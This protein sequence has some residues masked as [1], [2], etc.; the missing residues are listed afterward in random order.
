MGSVLI[1]E[2]YGQQGKMANQKRKEEKS[3]VRKDL[4]ISRK[5]ELKPPQRNIFTAGRHRSE[6]GEL[7]RQKKI[8]GLLSEED[9]SQKNEE[10]K[11]AVFDVKYI[12]HVFSGK[13]VVALLIFR[14]EMYAVE[15]GDVL[16]TGLTIGE[17]T[18]GS[19]Q[20]IGPDSKP[21]KV[22]LEGEEP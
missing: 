20:I 4:L 21:V 18:P 22:R 16:E 3:M 7:P 12:G 5:K 9:L 14:G 10:K 1:P 19:I 6:S 17:I 2:A 11:E 13:K 8:Q 15:A